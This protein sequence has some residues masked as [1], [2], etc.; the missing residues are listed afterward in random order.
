[1][2]DAR[3]RVV[4]EHVDP[5]IDAGR[6]PIKRTAGEPVV[7]EADAFAEG[8]DE[9]ACV[10]LD[11]P[12]R[13]TEWRETP[14]RPLVNDR[15]RGEFDVGG[16]GRHVYTL[17]GWVDHFHTWVRDLV[18]RLEAGQDVTVDLRIGAE[19]VIETAG[20]ATDVDAARLRQHA[21]ALTGAG[22]EHRALSLDL[23][24]LMARYPDRCHATR[25][26]RE[27]EVLVDRERA[28]FGA[29][30][31]LFPR[32]AAPVRGRHGTF[33]DVEARLPY[34]A[35][36][37]FDVLYLPPIHP[38]GRTYRKGR[39][40]S[41]KCEPGDVGSPWA[42]GGP[43]GGHKSVNPDLGTLDDFRHLVGAAK[44]HGLEIAMDIAF[45]A[46]PDHPYVREHPE[47]FRHRPDGAI[48]Y[49]ENPPKKYQ[50]IYPFDFEGAD[51][52]SLWD[53]LRSIFEFWI[54]QGVRIFR[55]D[56]PHTKPFAFWEWVIAE[57]RGRHPDVIFLSEAFTRPRVM[58]RLAKVGF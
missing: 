48:Q 45:Q 41:V 36:M 22:G 43:E 20:R 47:W 32:S 8:H 11:R 3:C 13:Q 6:Y 53:E 14:M 50:D 52:R 19:L 51:W 29:W 15:W 2:R 46:S 33:E 56:N 18:R 21:A 26:A 31:E 1:M 35:G 40:N 57:V 5:E 49:A 16:P 44:E 55:V 38:I 4:I 58:E 9:L 10:L 37:G 27:L 28:R 42:I 39:N 34:V 24:S 7:V 17:E 23:A 30:Y 54:E 25:Y 12:A